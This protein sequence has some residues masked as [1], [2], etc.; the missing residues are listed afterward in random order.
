MNSEKK[1]NSPPYYTGFDLQPINGQ[2][3]RGKTM[4]VLRDTNPIMAKFLLRFNRQAGTIGRRRITV[5]RMHVLAGLP[6][7][8]HGFLCSTSCGS[9]F[10]MQMYGQDL[11]RTDNRNRFL[12]F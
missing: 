1:G 11:V 9:T 12:H 10:L 4:K 8:D 2:W 5:Q 7:S 6:C 3:R